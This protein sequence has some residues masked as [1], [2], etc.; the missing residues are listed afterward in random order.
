VERWEWEQEGS[1]WG[2]GETNR[3]YWERNN[4]NFLSAKCAGTMVIQ[5]QIL[6][7]VVNP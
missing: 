2:V 6:V 1:N 3:E 4:W 5:I 7:G